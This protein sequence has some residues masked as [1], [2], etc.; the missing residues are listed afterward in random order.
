MPA[1]Q[2]YVALYPMAPYG[3]LFVASVG[4]CVVIGALLPKYRMILVWAGFA[5]G[6]LAI[7][8]AAPALP[9]GKTP[10]STFQIGSFI[11]AIALEI[12]AFRYAMPIAR[13][14]SERAMLAATL[15]IVGLHFFVMLPAFGILIG[16]L[17]ALCT[18]NAA[19]LWRLPNYPPN[20]AWLI[21]GCLKLTLGLLM[22]STA[23]TINP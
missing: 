16:I 17:A 7:T 15:G 11:L 4:L 21:D 10:P 23:A 8:L 12:A 14:H 2:H 1:L 19:V 9:H 22:L 3:G 5:L 18:L 6:S 20:P 13:R